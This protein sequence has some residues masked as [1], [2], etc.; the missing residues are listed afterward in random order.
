[1]TEDRGSGGE[2]VKPLPTWHL[3]ETELNISGHLPTIQ[4]HTWLGAIFPATE[5]AS[6][7]LDARLF[8]FLCPPQYFAHSWP[9][10]QLRMT[11]WKIEFLHLSDLERFPLISTR[12]Y[13]LCVTLQQARHLEVHA[14]EALVEPHR[15]NQIPPPPPVPPWQRGGSLASARPKSMALKFLCNS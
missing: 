7:V 11:L 3:L 12:D 1:M 2:R 8:T 13:R 4:R 5:C 10:R 6:A 14:Q 15:I 9:P